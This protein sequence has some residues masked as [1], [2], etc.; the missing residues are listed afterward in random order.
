[1]G[2]GVRQRYKRVQLN[3]KQEK[4]NESSQVSPLRLFVEVA[5]IN[6]PFTRTVNGKYKY[7]C[8]FFFRKRNQRGRENMRGSSPTTQHEDVR[9]TAANSINE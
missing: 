8:R 3:T 5:Y 7:L 9:E 6:G 4:K 1:M 2:R